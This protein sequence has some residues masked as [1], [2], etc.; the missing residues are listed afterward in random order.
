MAVSRLPVYTKQAVDTYSNPATR[1]QLKATWEQGLARLLDVAAPG[2]DHQLAFARAYA[3]AAHSD[4]A[5]ARIAGLLDGSQ[6]ID[7]LTVDTDLRWTLVTALA[8]AGRVD[9]DRIAEELRSDNTISGQE[10]AAA[11]RAARPTL[12]AKE[13]AWQDAVGRDDVANETQ[14]SIALAFNVAG[15]DEVL[16]PFVSRYLDSAAT[17][18][19]EKGTQRASVILEYMFPRALVTRETL[20]T[21]DA[22]LATSEANPA[23]KRYVREGRAD[24]ERALAAQA[25]DAQG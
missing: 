2:S 11:A 15:Q 24:I 17:L 14:R 16:E 8:A 4:E 23:A 6:V 18:W 13:Q 5:L 3:A 12:E 7:G 21:V 19:E 25:R 22:W 1:A 10:R 9:E 20:E